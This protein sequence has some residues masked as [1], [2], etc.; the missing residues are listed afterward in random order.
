MWTTEHNEVIIKF[1]RNTNLTVLIA[2][3]DPNTGF[4]INTQAPAYKMEEMSYLIRQQGVKLTTENIGKKLQFGTIKGN[5]I[6]SL[7]RIMTNV[8]AP[9]IFGNKSWPVSILLL[10]AFNSDLEAECKILN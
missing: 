6:E 4:H 5:H 2:Y 1:L 3:V 7:L 9:L 10:I 8:Y